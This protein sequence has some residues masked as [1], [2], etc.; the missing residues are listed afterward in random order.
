[1]A[2]KGI[3]TETRDGDIELWG[4]RLILTDA[5]YNY[6]LQTNFSEEL[7]AIL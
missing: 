2:E 5:F 6:H 1:M 3:F 7:Y 4:K